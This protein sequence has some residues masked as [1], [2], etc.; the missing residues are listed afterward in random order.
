M[1]FWE[2]ILGSYFVQVENIIL[3]GDLNFSF[4][5]VESWDHN[6]QVDSLT[7]FFKHIM[8]NNRLI[9]IKMA[10]TQPTWRNRR[11]GTAM[12]A[13]SLDTFLIKGTPNG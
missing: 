1:E 6:A 10:C 4:G 9:D 8:E 11:M 12:L 13:I 2:A 5:H 7:D 3:G